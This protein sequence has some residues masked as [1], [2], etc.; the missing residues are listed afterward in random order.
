[1]ADTLTL[2]IPVD[3]DELRPSA[4]QAANM[5]GFLR[6]R[7]GKTVTVTF[8]R[9]YEKRTDAQNRYY[10]GVVL[11]IIGNHTGNATEDLHEVIKAKFLPR[12]FITL[13]GREIEIDK[14]TKKLSVQEFTQYLDLVRAWAGQELGI[15]FP[16]LESTT[17]RTRQVSR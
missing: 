7:N 4:L 9:P 16:D 6:G 3:G 5:L 12:K 13:G 15:E 8:E 17:T 11:T 1:M 14:S 2:T 10:W